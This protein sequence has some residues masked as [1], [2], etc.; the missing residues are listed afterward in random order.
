MVIARFRIFELSKI[1]VRIGSHKP[2]RRT[3]GFFFIGNWVL[4]A[5]LKAQDTDIQQKKAEPG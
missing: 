1:N 2:V 4:V 3:L 5:E